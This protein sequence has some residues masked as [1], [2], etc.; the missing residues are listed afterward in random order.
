M[1]PTELFASLPD[2]FRSERAGDLHASYAFELS[3]EGGGMWTVHVADGA[4]HVTDGADPAADVSLRASADDWMAIVE[5]RKDP[6]LAF[7]TNKLKVSGNLQLAL[8]LREAI[9]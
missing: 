1:T 7:L 8:R 3:G 4:L 2:R 9:L 6:Q 5:G